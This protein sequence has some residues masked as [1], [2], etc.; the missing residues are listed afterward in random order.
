MLVTSLHGPHGSTRKPPDTTPAAFLFYGC[1]IY[2]SPL[3]PSTA[4]KSSSNVQVWSASLFIIAAVG[5]FCPLLPGF[6]VRQ[7]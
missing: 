7:Q 2:L 5:R 4:A 3:L 1:G 6:R